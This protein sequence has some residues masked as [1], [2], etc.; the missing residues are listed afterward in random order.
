MKALVRGGWRRERQNQENRQQQRGKPRLSG[1]SALPRLSRG[2]MAFDHGSP[3]EPA[4]GKILAFS[5]KM[6][7]L[8]FPYFIIPR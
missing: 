8:Y 4:F 6:P 7:I 3:F 1:F 5:I 2:F